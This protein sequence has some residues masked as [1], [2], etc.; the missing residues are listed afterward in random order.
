[1][2]LSMEV[3]AAALHAPVGLNLGGDAPE[4][5]ALAILAEAHARC[6]GGSA[7][8]RRITADEM[9]QHLAERTTTTTIC[10]LDLAAPLE[11]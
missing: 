11:K 4:S 7:H 1:M 2:N 8:S 3:V 10:T 9:K 5:I 6:I